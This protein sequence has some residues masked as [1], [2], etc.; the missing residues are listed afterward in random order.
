MRTLFL[1]ALAAA[2]A[3]LNTKDRGRVIRIAEEILP[4]GPCIARAWNRIVG[5]QA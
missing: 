3:A 5:A 4:E 2:L 1:L